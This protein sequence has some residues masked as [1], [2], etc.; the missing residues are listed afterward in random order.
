MKTKAALLW[1]PDTDW[2]VEEVDLRDPV[3][4]EVQ[5]RMVAAGMCRSDE[6]VRNGTTPPGLYPMVGGHEGAGVITKVGAGVNQYSVGDHV[7]LAF[8]PACGTCASCSR[9][10]QNLCDEGANLM[11][12]GETHGG[13]RVTIDGREAA[14]MCLLGT[15]SPYVT[16][17][18]NAVIR[19]EKD[20][21][22]EPAA[23]LGCA[24]PTGW[25]SATVSADLR[26]GDVAVVVGIGGVGLNAVQGA[27]A[28]GARIVAAVDPVA[29]KLEKAREFGATH[30]FSSMS[31]A[32]AQLPELTWG[33][34]ADAA[35]LTVSELQAE[36]IGE[37]M[38]LIG[39]HGT[40]VVT[41]MAAH[42]LTSASLSLNELAVYQK[43]IQG[44][45]F[46]G[47][48]PRSQI[49]NI[50]HQYRQ[51]RLKLDELIT[52]TYSL[53]QINQGYA[54]LRAGLIARGIVRYTE[55]DW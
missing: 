44:S 1:S 41:A 34:M 54:D 43:R 33:K 20:I 37:A 19:I 18:T 40:V 28:S 45:I 23:L 35:I 47:S 48:S 6:H 17:H 5:V 16:V 39:K 46:G 30:V 21:P 15:F 29:F 22:L 55:N 49:P 25:G 4:G 36:H 53:G 26:P 50:L 3:A 42:S 2:S 13:P 12:G 31:E 14:T 38:A 8:I 10:W 9:G 52:G 32:A 11:G 51:G 24:V 27:A 7:V